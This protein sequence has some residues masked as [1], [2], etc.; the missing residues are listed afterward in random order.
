MASVNL[1][2]DMRQTNGSL[3]QTLLSYIFG[4]KTIF[5]YNFYR[6]Y[7]TGD[8]IVAPNEET[9]KVEVLEAIEDGITKA[10]DRSKWKT[11]TIGSGSNIDIDYSELI[12]LSQEQPTSNNNMVWFYPV[13]EIESTFHPDIIAPDYSTVDDIQT[14][15]TVFDDS[16]PMVEEGA[17]EEENI[18][19]YFDIENTEPYD[20][21]IEEDTGAD[22]VLTL[23]EQ[24]DVVVSD[25]VPTD[26]ALLWL[27]TDITDDDI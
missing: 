16:F 25:D 27:D 19:L 15:S 14:L 18:E 8:M 22:S 24:S 26:D 9:G 23:D 5:A 2:R 13:S 4:N 20:G 12:V 10:F 21:V 6:T 1:V 7:N 11:A 3:L 17:P